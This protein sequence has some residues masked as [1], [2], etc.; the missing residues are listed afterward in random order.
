MIDSLAESITPS[1]KKKDVAI[2][3]S[4]YKTIFTWS[5]SIYQTTWITVIFWWCLWGIVELIWQLTNWRWLK[6]IVALSDAHESQIIGITTFALG[7]Y[8][9]V[10]YSRWWNLYNAIPSPDDIAMCIHV[11]LPKPE[12]F[13][14]KKKL[15]RY[16][17]LSQ[18]LVFAWLSPDFTDKYPT[19]NSLV[20]KNLLTFDEKLRLKRSIISDYNV[21]PYWTPYV[22]FQGLIQQEFVKKAIDSDLLFNHLFQTAEKFNEGCASII[23]SREVSVPLDFSQVCSLLVWGSWFMGT[24]GWHG[25]SKV[26]EDNAEGIAIPIYDFFL[27]TI[28]VGW[29]NGTIV[30]LF[31]FAVRSDGFDLVK[32][33]E[34][35]VRVTK[36]MCSCPMTEEYVNEQVDHEQRQYLVPKPVGLP[37]RPGGVE[38]SVLYSTDSEHSEPNSLPSDPHVTFVGVEEHNSANDVDLTSSEVNDANDVYLNSRFIHPTVSEEHSSNLFGWFTTNSKLI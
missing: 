26:V 8:T 35:D 25:C 3:A 36:L 33:F 30:L 11:S 6:Y 28:L 23:K 29:L 15:I 2:L 31:P 12:Q 38:E 13:E 22:W 18:A 32:I 34:R 4:I 1:I 37:P 9:Y 10:L 5:R 17:L 20:Q 7:F 14:L 24:L 21:C 16:T 27:C 19:L